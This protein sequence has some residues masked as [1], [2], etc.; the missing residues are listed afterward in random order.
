VSKNTNDPASDVLIQEVDED[1]RHE[2]MLKAWKRFAPY[3]LGVALLVIVGVAGQEIWKKQ[4]AE[5]RIKES[6]AFA[7]A[8]ILGDQG[9]H[10]EAEEAFA[11]LAAE[12]KTGQGVL[13]KLRQASL[14]ANSGDIQG[15]V[16]A[17]ES[18]VANKNAPQVYRDLAVIKI[19]L[20]TIDSAE[21]AALS[22]R[23]A[24]VAAAGPWRH[25]ALEMQALLALRQGDV[26]K[27]RALY[28]S[29]ADAADAP[30]NLRG[31]AAEMLAALGRA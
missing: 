11:K 16:A 31:R 20:L 6:G 7:A 5:T 15:A 4:Q 12:A 10:K 3:I 29:I 24:P 1:L 8:L 14:Q 2:E 22:G 18:V 26:A 30:R 9:K 21:P 28:S 23:L 13:A 27:A 17:C 19:G 25:S